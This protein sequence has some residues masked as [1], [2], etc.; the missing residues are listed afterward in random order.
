MIKPGAPRVPYA[1]AVFADRGVVGIRAIHS[2]SHTQYDRREHT[3]HT[4]LL[5]AE[6]ASQMF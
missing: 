5:L 3:T 2:F 4:A 1:G 6:R